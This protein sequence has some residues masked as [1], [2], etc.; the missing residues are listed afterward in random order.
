[1]KTLI[2]KKSQLA[3]EIQVPSSKSQTHRAILFGSLAKSKSVV[4]YPLNS[5]DSLAMIEACRHLGAK[6]EIH[7][8]HL[9][10]HGVG[11]KI[12]GSEDVINA[13]NSGI[14]LRFV[15]A[16]A[17]LGSQP[18][19]ITGDHSIRHQ[20]SMQTMLHSLKQ[21]GAKKAISTREEGFAPIIIQGPIKPGRCQIADGSDSQNVSPLLIAGAFLDGALEV[22]V[23][24]P[25]EKPWIDMT[26]DWLKRLGV[27]YQNHH[28]EKY[29][30]QG[31]GSYSGF[32]Y[33]V[34]GDWSS[35]AFPIAAALVTQSELT[36][37]NLDIFD[38]Q[39]DKKIV[40]IFTQ[41]GAR[42]LI[43]DKKK[44]IRVSAGEQ[45]RGV[46]VDIND[47]ID[48]ITIIAA[49]A[50]YAEGE[51]RIVNAAV[52]RQKEC[53]RIACM[54]VELNKMGAHVQETADG[55]IVKG[56]ALKGTRV[57]SHGDHRMAMSLAVAGMGAKGETQ[58]HE[59]GCMGKTYPSF[60]TDF[61]NMGAHL[62]YR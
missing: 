41:M 12:V 59:A 26:L 25:G 18:I 10:I 22:E 57:L 2:V 1:M 34:P 14:V 3:H 32:E 52:A 58:I 36:I 11:G 28:Y 45:L 29:I 16:I 23:Y 47:C 24:N 6:I 13:H 35:A 61:Q 27:P 51:T 17:A 62:E 40:D 9:D 56:A 31:I 7:E 5:Q 46:T 60:V 55:L 30:V 50:C 38:L 49:V 19:V 53:D 44:T 54:A 20:R 48:A 39:G 43:D 42:F 4:R 21:L 37:K 8:N 33:T 15:A